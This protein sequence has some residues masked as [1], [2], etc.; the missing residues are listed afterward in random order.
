MLNKKELVYLGPLYQEKDVM[1]FFQF[2][3]KKEAIIQEVEKNATKLCRIFNYKLDLLHKIS[4]KYTIEYESYS[5]IFNTT[6]LVKERKN[7]TS[8][9]ISDKVVSQEEFFESL[10]ISY[11]MNTMENLKDI[12]I[13]PNPDNDH[14]DFI[15]IVKFLPETK[16]RKLLF[17]KDV[18]K[19]QYLEFLQTSH[20]I[21]K[22]QL[23]FATFDA[24]NYSP[25]LNN[26]IITIFDNFYEFTLNK[27]ENNE[28]LDV[29]K[30]L[31]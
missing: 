22:E 21:T 10:Y 12:H 11:I 4:I 27:L 24:K 17:V 2:F 20:K 9:S 7:E 13:K 16:Q 23:Q 25:F 26:E 28:K 15:N 30:E 31:I 5:N 14:F 18:D 19:N 8:F 29:L 6:D 1:Q 3:L